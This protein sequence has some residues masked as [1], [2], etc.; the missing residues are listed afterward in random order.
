MITLNAGEAYGTVFTLMGSKALGADMVLCLEDAKIGVLPASAAVAFL[1]NDKITGDVS[2]A[3]LEAEWNNVV[4]TPVAAARAGEVDD[5]IS[6]AEIRQRLTAAVMMLQAKSKG[7][8]YRRHV[9][10]PL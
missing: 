10:M 8:P 7:S 5:I 1:W 3:D 2:R 4:G 9:N 6:A